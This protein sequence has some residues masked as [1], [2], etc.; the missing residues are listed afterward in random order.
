MVSKKLK[1]NSGVSQLD[2]LLDGLYIGDNVVWHDE[3]GSLAGVFCLNFIQAS[4]ERNKPII[5]V[6]FDRS[7][8]NLLDKLGSLAYY[9]H[10]II[11]DC[12]TFG[13]GAGSI[14]FL[15]FYEKK[16]TDLPCRVVRVDEP[17]KAD[18]VMDA[19]Y[20]IHETLE[21]DVRF[22]F[23]SLTGMQELWGGEQHLINFYSHS[24]PRL[25]ELN[26]IAYWVIE[27]KAHSPTIRAQINQIVLATPGQGRAVQVDANRLVLAV[28][29]DELAGKDEG[30]AKI[31][32]ED[33]GRP[34]VDLL[35]VPCQEPSIGLGGLNA[36][37]V[38]EVFVGV[39]GG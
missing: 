35:V 6:S 25:Y 2:Q 10:L 7:P 24:C 14:V 12:F 30:A 9:Q 26:T 36:L 16:E 37:L 23:E 33:A 19:L 17:R 3:A 15:K 34:V 1:V 20:D 31:F 38:K 32:P 13:K 28:Q 22:V 11:L 5:Y 21:G 27:K 29:L 4:Q 39:A 18:R 8:K